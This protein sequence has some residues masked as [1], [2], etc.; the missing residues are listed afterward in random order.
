LI[1]KYTQIDIS[2]KAF[3][4]LAERDEVRVGKNN[5]VYPGDL[6]GG[7]MDLT[8]IAHSG[9]LSKVRLKLRSDRRI[10]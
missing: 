7:V 10:E 3:E 1:K 2:A 8:P 5:D 4:E 6:R 9:I